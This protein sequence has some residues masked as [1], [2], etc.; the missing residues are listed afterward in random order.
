MAESKYMISHKTQQAQ[1]TTQQSG[2]VRESCYDI[3]R[4]VASDVRKTKQGEG[5]KK[6]I[7]PLPTLATATTTTT[8]T[9]HRVDGSRNANFRTL[10]FRTQHNEAKHG[11]LSGGLVK[12]RKWITKVVI[13]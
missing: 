8:T 6:I 2:T 7:N 9:P 4:S 5:E 13:T 11:A 1:R 12:W 10:N 3:Q